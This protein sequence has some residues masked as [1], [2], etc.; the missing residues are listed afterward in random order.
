MLRQRAAKRPGSAHVV[1]ELP[2]PEV[3]RL[4]GW[5]AASRFLLLH[6]SPGKSRQ[7]EA[8]LQDAN[9]FYAMTA[10]RA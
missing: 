2:N 10:R 6:G 9:Y 4:R 1:W 8:S 5:V 3:M 7:T